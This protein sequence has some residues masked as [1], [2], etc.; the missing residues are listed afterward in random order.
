M[1]KSLTDNEASETSWEQAPRN[2]AVVQ[3]RSLGHQQGFGELAGPWS[4]GDIRATHMENMR[5][6]DNLLTTKERTIAKNG[7]VP[8]C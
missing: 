1:H 6:K 2:A 5:T 8:W 4:S 7:I 3:C